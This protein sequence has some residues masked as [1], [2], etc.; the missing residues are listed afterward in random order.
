M[1]YDDALAT[2]TPGHGRMVRM[3][4]LGA[5]IWIE[6]RDEDPTGDAAL[7]GEEAPYLFVVLSNGDLVRWHASPDDLTAD[8]WMAA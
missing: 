5:G 3:S 7:T 2:L 8:D 1:T 4:R 6:M